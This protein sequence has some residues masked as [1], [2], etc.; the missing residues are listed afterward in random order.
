MRDLEEIL[1][2]ISLLKSFVKLL[3]SNYPHQ[4]NLNPGK[5]FLKII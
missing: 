3:E 1:Y 4:A 5:D 2:R